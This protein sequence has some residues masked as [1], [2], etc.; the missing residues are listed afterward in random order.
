ME[1]KFSFSGDNGVIG[2]LLPDDS[3]IK[4]GGVFGEFV[5]SKNGFDEVENKF[6]FADNGEEEE[7][8]STSIGNSKFSKF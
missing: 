4:F 5:P 3:S 2:E 7:S 6:S 8:K 1:K